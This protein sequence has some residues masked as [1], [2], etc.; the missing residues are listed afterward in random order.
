MPSIS[1]LD[2]P[3]R[4]ENPLFPMNRRMTWSGYRTP[5]FLLIAV[6]YQHPERGPENSFGSTKL[7]RPVPTLCMQGHGFTLRPACALQQV[8][9][10]YPSWCPTETVQHLQGGGDGHAE[11][12][13]DFGQH[14]PT[15]VSIGMHYG[16]HGSKDLIQ[17]FCPDQ[18]DLAE[19]M[20]MAIM[21]RPY[22]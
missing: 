20:I 2:P 3:A 14:R 9:S 17:T 4:V 21:G 18:A 1:A 8:W 10:D 12:Q 22:I 5:C 19:L 6:R 13:T 11:G 15:L 16:M 7:C